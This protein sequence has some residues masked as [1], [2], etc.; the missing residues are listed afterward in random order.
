MGPF[1]ASDIT[2]G[3][4]VT[5]VIVVGWI[6][7]ERGTW[8]FSFGFKVVPK[9]KRKAATPAAAPAVAPLPVAEPAPGAV[10]L[11]PEGRMT[12]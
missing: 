2:A 5:L 11:R 1:E 4:I 12:G 7:A 9:A 3:A 10:Q 6:G 8:E